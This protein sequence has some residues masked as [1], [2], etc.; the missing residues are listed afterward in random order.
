MKK[1]LSLFVL[2]FVFIFM[3]HVKN[4]AFAQEAV[5]EVANQEASQPV[6]VA[7][8]NGG[9]KAV[10]VLKEVD[11]KIPDS[12]PP[13]LVGVASF[14][15]GDVGLRLFPTAKPKSLILLIAAIFG[16]LGSIFS[17]LSGLADNLV[18]NVKDPAPPVPPV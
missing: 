6:A 4:V 7:A 17:K 5:A 9:E 3:F 2:M 11:S 12:I 10:A 13:W 8:S 1:L 15:I 16:L 14:F 18:Q